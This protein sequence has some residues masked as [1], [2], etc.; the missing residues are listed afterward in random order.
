MKATIRPRRAGQLV[1]HCH[2]HNVV[3]T[4]TVAPHHATPWH[5]EQD[6]DN[7]DD[8]HA[9][10]CDDTKTRPVKRSLFDFGN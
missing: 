5:K 4:S 7:Q 3:T 10:T 2:A 1:N 9:L 6:H 8:G